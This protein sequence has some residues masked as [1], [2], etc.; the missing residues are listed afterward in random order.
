MEP[1][2]IFGLFTLFT[3]Y[4][5]WYPI[6][7][8]TINPHFPLPARIAGTIQL[9]VT[10]NSAVSMFRNVMWPD[11]NPSTP[12]NEPLLNNVTPLIK[13]QFQ[14]FL[15][16]W[17]YKLEKHITENTECPISTVTSYS[18]PTPTLQTMTANITEPQS[19]PAPLDFNSWVGYTFYQFAEKEVRRSPNMY[20]LAAIFIL[21]NYWLVRSARRP[22]V[23]EELEAAKEVPIDKL[24]ELRDELLAHKARLHLVEVK[25]EGLALADDQRRF[26]RTAPRQIPQVGESE[27]AAAE[28]QTLPASQPG[29]PEFDS[30]QEQ[31]TEMRQDLVSLKSSSET[32]SEQLSENIAFVM[33]TIKELQKESESTSRTRIMNDM[34]SVK[35]SVLED[36][37][38][39]LTPLSN[40]ISDMEASTSSPGGELGR[41]AS[42]MSQTME[43]INVLRRE[44]ER[45]KRKLPADLASIKTE[46]SREYKLK[47]DAVEKQVLELKQTACLSKDE[48]DDILPQRVSSIMGIIDE[49][50]EDSASGAPIDS[51]KKE[52]AGLKSS[53]KAVE[54]AV[55]EIGD[56]TK[57]QDVHHLRVSL[58]ALQAESTRSLQELS[59]RLD[60]V[61]QDIQVEWR[62]KHQQFDQ[63]IAMVESKLQGLEHSAL[64][65]SN[66]L[67]V[68]SQLEALNTKVEL[69][70]SLF[71]RV[72]DECATKFEQKSLS[73]DVKLL[74]GRVNQLESIPQKD[75]PSA[76]K[77]EHIIKLR[78]LGKSYVALR[79]QI[80]EIKDTLTTLISDE[81]PQHHSET[82]D[83][84]TESIRLR[85]SQIEKDIEARYAY[86]ED[87]LK[88][89]N[90]LQLDG[91]RP[92]DLQR[93][94]KDLSE[95]E[96]Y[97]YTTQNI[98]NLAV[99]RI[100]D[101][102]QHIETLREGNATNYKDIRRCLDKL[103][104]SGTIVPLSAPIKPKPVPGEPKPPVHIDLSVGKK[105]NSQVSSSPQDRGDKNI[106]RFDPRYKGN[107][108]P[109][110]S[111]IESNLSK[112]SE[113]LK[114]TSQD[115]NIS[116]YDPRYQGSDKFR[117]SYPE[118]GSS[119]ASKAKG[120]LNPKA[121]SFEER[122][123]SS[124]N[125]SP[126]SR[127]SVAQSESTGKEN[128]EVEMMTEN[129]KPE[130]GEDAIKS[131]VEIMSL[132]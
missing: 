81:I 89:L 5:L 132:Q 100:T 107:D 109:V 97:A 32:R 98:L 34:V 19:Y 129:E 87:V 64:A 1:T 9:T 118:P 36:L 4:G 50:K 11:L 114:K 82:L 110:G 75:P 26:S 24:K 66:L 78:D 3:I 7:L 69:N 30:L 88:C 68:L 92:I 59:S 95:I 127:A 33:N 53:L 106:S 96:N 91:K 86:K 83:K 112:R 102:E 48:L 45:V 25:V 90:A 108:K 47:F 121:D 44:F 42:Q 20:T 94:K 80:G 119:E 14:E 16:K 85:T 84:L 60:I 76:M 122:P 57:R 63:W 70:D 115:K 111:D 125:G 13:N 38:S 41:F 27:Q 46:I 117:K 77:E 2:I 73:A 123:K 72:E 126:A 79:S 67:S 56:K 58:E 104:I 18:T 65:E 10:T 61:M 131:L 8:T 28:A 51:V 120:K 54:H 103:G 22:E 6:P 37:K 12:P 15:D 99:E 17:D 101:N 29:K 55:K 130:V 35:K 31:L 105:S 74:E 62:V 39:Q 116:R 23:R 71:K 49:A 40:R 21:V 128:T 113:S 43:S 52:M 124:G 93:L